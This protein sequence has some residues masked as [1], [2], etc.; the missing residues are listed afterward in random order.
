M[1][2]KIHI[3]KCI[4]SL[5]FMPCCLKIK[6]LDFM[7]KCK[8]TIC[9]TDKIHIQKCITSLLFMACGLKIKSLDSMSECKQTIWRGKFLTKPHIFRKSHIPI[10][11][12]KVFLGILLYM[13]MPP[14]NI[15]ILFRLETKFIY[16]VGSNES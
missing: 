16:N 14:R 12:P 6:S 11:L 1:T 15:H 10:G 13:L 4:T 8:Q 9:V 7:S 2:D 5:L 3:P